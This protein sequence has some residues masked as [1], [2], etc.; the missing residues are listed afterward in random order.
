[1]HRWRLWSLAPADWAIGSA[2]PTKI[3]PTPLPP[4]I[5]IIFMFLRRFECD[6]R[7]QAPA[8][9]QDTHMPK[10][11]SLYPILYQGS[12]GKK[13]P[14]SACVSFFSRFFGRCPITSC[15]SFLTS[16]RIESPANKPRIFSLYKCPWSS[17]DS[18]PPAYLGLVVGF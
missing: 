7:W 15:S 10:S 8:R 1:M 12:A 9:N 3:L 11:R 5:R 18:L 16:S 4:M 2:M 6:P 14:R 17:N 13:G